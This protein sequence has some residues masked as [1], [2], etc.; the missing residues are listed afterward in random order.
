MEKASR[1]KDEKTHF[2]A[3]VVMCMQVVI[4]LILEQI[5]IRPLQINQRYVKRPVVNGTEQ[6]ALNVIL[7]WFGFLLDKSF[8]YSK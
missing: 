5:M 8:I 4:L 2:G 7:N 1:K 6:L 3:V